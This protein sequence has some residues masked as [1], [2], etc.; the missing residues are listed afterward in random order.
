MSNSSAN[1]SFAEIVKQTVTTVKTV[2]RTVKVEKYSPVKASNVRSMIT[3]T[4][5]YKRKRQELDSVSPIKC[6]ER[7]IRV[8]SPDRV[9]GVCDKVMEKQSLRFTVRKR[10]T[11]SVNKSRRLVSSKVGSKVTSTATQTKAQEEEDNVLIQKA[12]DEVSQYHQARSQMAILL[13]IEQEKCLVLRSALVNILERSE[14]SIGNHEVNSINLNESIIAS[15]KP[16]L[17]TTDGLKAYHEEIN[18]AVRIKSKIHCGILSALKSIKLQCDSTFVE[19]KQRHKLATKKKHPWS[20]KT[21]SCRTISQSSSNNSEPAQSQNGILSRNISS[22]RILFNSSAKLLRAPLSVNFSVPL[23]QSLNPNDDEVP[24]FS[25]SIS[26][27][28]IEIDIPEKPK[29]VILVP[30]SRVD[31]SGIWNVSIPENI[32]LSLLNISQSSSVN[33]SSEALQPEIDHLQRDWNN[34]AASH[35]VDDDDVGSL[36]DFDS[37]PGPSTSNSQIRVKQEADSSEE[38]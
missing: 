22:K 28:K 5:A 38:M 15:K 36:L 24:D 16:N 21:G 23:E 12:M 6:T 8:N 25:T 20:A 29:P 2:V 34:F 11:N 32:D 4:P 13:A 30:I 1:S 3:S 10:K 7:V 35:R 19:L 9:K 27:T 14:I 26:D 17:S 31:P 33:I 37:S 18:R